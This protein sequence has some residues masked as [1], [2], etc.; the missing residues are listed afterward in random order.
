[1]KVTTGRIRGAATGEQNVPVTPE[2]FDAWLAE[3][4]KETAIWM[5]EWVADDEDQL[6]RERYGNV[7]ALSRWGAIARS[8]V[9]RLREMDTLCVQRDPWN[10]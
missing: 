1:M 3:H 4:D 2:Q 10:L 7:S 9:D 6:T 8:K 5:L